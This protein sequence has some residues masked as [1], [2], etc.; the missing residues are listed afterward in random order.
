MALGAKAGRSRDRGGRFRDGTF[1]PGRRG[2]VLHAATLRADEVMMM[3]TGEVLAELPAREFAIGDDAVDDSCLFEDDQV[4]VDRA[5]GEVGAALEDL[6]DRDRPAGLVEN[7]DQRSPV[8]GEA[9]S[10]GV[11]PQRRGGLHAGAVVG[12]LLGDGHGPSVPSLLG[13]SMGLAA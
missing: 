11:Q 10:D 1:E 8:G 12:A 7:L 6:G 3:V 2:G 5:L 4:P 13:C 9:L